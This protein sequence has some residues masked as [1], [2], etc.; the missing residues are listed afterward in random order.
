M[1][2]RTISL[3]LLAV[4]ALGCGGDPPRANEPPTAREK[5]RREAAATGE[6]SSGRKWGGWR[7]NRRRRQGVLG[8]RHKC[9]QAEV[10]ACGAGGGGGGRC[11]TPGGGPATV[12]CA[13]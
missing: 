6:T 1:S 4:L 12:A 3:G 9:L 11:E 2:F 5:Q 8:V 13:K 10:A 7:F